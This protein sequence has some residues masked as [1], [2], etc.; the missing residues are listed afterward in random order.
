MPKGSAFAM[1]KAI[2]INLSNEI[3]INATVKNLQKAVKKFFDR[4]DVSRISPDVKKLVCDPSEP[5]NKVPL[6]YRLS[7]LKMLHAK[8]EAE[9]E[10]SCSYQ[11][12]CNYAPY[13]VVKPKP[14][15]WGSC[16]C[17]TCL[18]PEL[19]LQKLQ[20]LANDKTFVIDENSK[21]DNL[22]KRVN[23]LSIEK[24]QV[25]GMVQFYL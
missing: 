14:T 18:N 8:F 4:D 25:T 3:R 6:R 7:T 9:S 17:R 16:L 19:K 21:L 12:F 1:R 2:G 5:G 22:I 13:Y 20:S 11:T 10:S 23:N 24:Q 15:D